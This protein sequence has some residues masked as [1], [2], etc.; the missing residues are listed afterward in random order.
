[1][2][3][4]GGAVRLGDAAWERL[5]PTGEGDDTAVQAARTWFGGDRLEAGVTRRSVPLALPAGPEAGAVV[6]KVGGRDGA[7]RAVAAWAVLEPG[8]R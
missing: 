7:G 3:A 8:Q 2:T 6:F 5:W 1:V 4:H